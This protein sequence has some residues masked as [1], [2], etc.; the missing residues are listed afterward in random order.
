MSVDEYQAIKEHVKETVKMIMDH[1][2]IDEE[3]DRYC[4][5][6]LEAKTKQGYKQRSKNK[7]C[8]KRAVFREQET[9]RRE[10][11]QNPQFL[12]DVSVAKSINCV[13]KAQ[14]IAMKDAQEANE[15]LL[16]DV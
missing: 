4:T 12:A 14:W 5:R 8:V 6:G 16:D 2:D 3:D 13:Y 10:G 11:I 15:Y 7:A 9:R 1:Q